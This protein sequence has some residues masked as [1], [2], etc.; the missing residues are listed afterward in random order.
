MQKVKGK[1]KRDEISYLRKDHQREQFF[2]Q[3]NDFTENFYLQY[4]SF[5][6]FIQM[7]R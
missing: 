5:Y 6:Y 3:F 7:I 2:R 4:K 1:I